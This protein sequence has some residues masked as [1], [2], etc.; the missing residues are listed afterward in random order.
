V[1]SSVA[2]V[3]AVSVAVL[4]AA[5]VPGNDGTTRQFA[6]GTIATR[7]VDVML[8]QERAGVAVDHAHHVASRWTA[9]V[10]PI[11]PGGTE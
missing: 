2:A 5:S 9:T 7:A 6:A 8:A 1:V 3:R 10:V 4:V 11:R